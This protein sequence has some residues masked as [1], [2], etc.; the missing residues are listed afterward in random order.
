M[1]IRPA[2]GSL[3]SGPRVA[4]EK[5]RWDI[6]YQQTAVANQHIVPESTR[7]LAIENVLFYHTASWQQ[8]LT[9]WFRQSQTT[10]APNNTLAPLLEILVARVRKDKHWRRNRCSP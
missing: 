3:F 9:I 4:C 8:H 1:L 7:T 10:L 2:G 6:Q 5:A